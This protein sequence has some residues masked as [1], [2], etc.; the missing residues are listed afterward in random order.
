M[1]TF[2]LYA[3]YNQ[4]NG[5]STDTR[6]I[7]NDSLFFALKGENFDANDFALEAIE[8]GAAYAVVDKKEFQK[9][10]N[11]KLIVVDDTLK[12][13]QDLAAFHRFH[14]GLPIIALT[15]SNGKTT[16]KELIH[17]VLKTKYNTIATIGNLNNHIGVPLTL[18][19]MTEETD[20]AIIEM[21]ANHQNEIALLC[22]ITQPDFGL[23]TNFGRAHLEGFGGIEG[24]IKGKSEMYDYLNA[25]NKT[26]FLNFDDPLQNN[27]TQNINRYGFSLQKH[28]LANVHLSNAVAQPMASLKFDDNEIITNLTGLYN[29]PNISFAITIGNYFNVPIQ[30]ITEAISKYTP[31]N[32]RSQWIQKNNKKILL[33]AYNANPSSMQVAISNFK[34]LDET[35]KLMILGDMFE[36]GEET[37]KEHLVVIREAIASDIPVYFVGDNFHKNQVSSNLIQYFKNTLEVHSFLETNPCNFTTILIK[38][39]RAMALEKI[40]ENL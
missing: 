17:T 26:A 40:I 27:K 20:L 37:N 34:Q 14:L 25:N 23:I 16:T 36:L 11:S 18:L 32:N 28:S 29:L 35:N 4:C 9:L 3:I 39:S 21:G 24:V 19:R 22:E 2:E 5:V 33:D 7:T 10:N 12:A 30:Q 31:Q 1:E 38:G 6:N 15:G 13:L 8:K